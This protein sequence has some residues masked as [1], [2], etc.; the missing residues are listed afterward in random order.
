VDPSETSF[1]PRGE[2]QSDGRTK[3]HEETKKPHGMLAAFV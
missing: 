1:T 2:Q 3:G